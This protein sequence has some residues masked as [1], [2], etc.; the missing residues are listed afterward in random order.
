MHSNKQYSLTLQITTFIQF[1][2][3]SNTLSNKKKKKKRN[4][5]KNSEV[6]YK[7]VWD[8]T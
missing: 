7:H 1:E 6:T 8:R 4:K 2:K 5:N 3:I